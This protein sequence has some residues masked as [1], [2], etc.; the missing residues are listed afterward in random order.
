MLEENSVYVT[1]YAKLG[2][3]VTW[4][5]DDAVMVIEATKFNIYIYLYSQSKKIL[6]F[7]MRSTDY[8]L[9][10]LLVKCIGRSIAETNLVQV[11]RKVCT[12]RRMV[13]E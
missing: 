11:T 3:T 7:E 8:E 13:I 9:Y 2:L 10:W 4:N 12:T 6:Y 1:L 5:R